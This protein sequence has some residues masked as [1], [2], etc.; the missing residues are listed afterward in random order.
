M[1]IQTSSSASVS[2]SAV[3]IF[4]LLLPTN[5]SLDSYQGF[6]GINGQ[7]YPF[8]LHFSSSKSELNDIPLSKRKT[9]ENKSCTG[10]FVA[11]DSEL[12]DL[13][14]GY[15]DL[16]QNKLEISRDLA[17]FLLEFKDIL[18]RVVLCKGT[19][20][21]PPHPKFYAR[22]LTE[23]DS[24]GWDKLISIHPLLTSV[25]I[26]LK[27][28]SGR[29]HVLTVSF[30]SDYPNQPPRCLADIPSN[31]I[32]SELIKSNGSIGLN[33]NSN[34]TNNMS[35]NPVG[36]LQFHWQPQT[37]SMVDIIKHFQQVLSRFQDLWF[38]LEDLDEHTWV[39]EPEHP[40][41]SS[42]SRRLALGSRCSIH[43][44][45]DPNRPRALPE[46]HFLGPDKNL[47]PFRERFHQG[48]KHWNIQ[49]LPRENLEAIL[50]ISFPSPKTTNK[51]DFS[52]ECG[53]CYAYRLEG[54]IPERICD[55]QKCAK[56]FHT[57]CLF[58]WLKAIPN[59]HQSFDTIFGECPYCSSP[60]TVKL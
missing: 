7:E 10:R 14:R 17:S 48:I 50:E 8:R 31:I 53:I 49:R 30:P 9:S 2:L 42:T 36:Q 26:R 21:N 32:D 1:N 35:G 5:L 58:E 38:V 11:C 57:T 55:N 52:E 34:S 15:E 47:A 3:E 12:R 43:V 29:D 27:D 45:I 4:P 22:I 40:S 37:S 25:D 6:V 19:K 56:P 20:E 54:N 46:C 44:I 28:E 23:M 33:S 51:E 41:R 16:I 39:L 24:I 59:S 60:I 18:E 13:L